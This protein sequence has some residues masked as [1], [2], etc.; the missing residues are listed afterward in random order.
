MLHALC[1]ITTWQ[2]LP[3]LEYLL[4]HIAEAESMQILV[5]RH[6]C[7]ACVSVSIHVELCVAVT[8]ATRGYSVLCF[9]FSILC[10]REGC[11]GTYWMWSLFSSWSN[12]QRSDVRVCVCVCVC[13]CV[14]CVCVVCVCCVCVCV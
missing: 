5:L 7:I 4:T 12:L 3:M 10:V 2:G 11:R 14:V 9:S 1:D 13:V 6:L 8:V